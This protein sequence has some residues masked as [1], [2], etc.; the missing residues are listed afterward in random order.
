M[1]LLTELDFSLP[2]K[3]PVVIFSLVLFIILFSPI[4]FNKIKVPHI[5]GLILAGVIIGPY[6]FNLLLRDSSIVL[7]GTV[8]LIYIMFTAGLEI[9]MEEF[10]KTRVKSLVFGLFT[11][12]VPIIL[13]TAAAYYILKFSIPSA[14]LLASM[15]SAHTLLAYPIV[16]KYGITRMK[17]VTLT[18]GGT[19]IT[20]ILSLLVL[21]VVTGM[22][23]GEIGAAFWLRLVVS[24]AIFGVI[25]FLGFPL[26][27]RWF[28]KQFD[29]NISQYIFVLAMVFL[30]SFLAEVAGLE[31][32]VGAFL[33]GLA[34]NRFIPHVSPLMNRIDFVGNAFFIPFFLIGVGMLVD[35]SVLFKG[36]GA[37]KVAAVMITVAVLSKYIAAWLT[38]KS[39]KLSSS[40]R[41]LIFGLSTARVGAS[42]AVV[43]VGYNTILAETATGEPIRLLSEDVLNGTIL[44][45]LITCT[46]SS[47]TVE[48]ASQKIALKEE[49]AVVEDGKSNQKILISLA[50]P[51]TVAELVDFGLLL[52]PKKS[53]IPVYA[54]HVI[55]D[56]TDSDKSLAVG[57]KMIDRALKH[58]S[59]TENTLIPLTRFDMNI[60]NGITYTIKE[61]NIS[62]VLIGLHQNSNQEDFLGPVA[63][64]ILERTSE[65]I[66]IYKSIQPFNTLKRMVVAVPPHAESEPGFVHWLNKLGTIAKE[67]GLPIVFY[68]ANEALEHLKNHFSS[69]SVKVDCKPFHNWDDFL[70]FSRELKQNDLFWIISSRKGHIS[71][72]EQLE[73]LPYYLSNYLTNNSFIILY[74]KQM[75][76]DM[77]G[78]E[79]FI[80]T[81][82]DKIN[83]VNKAG[84][85]LKRL[86]RRI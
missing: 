83:V 50:Y 42:L 12:L 73:K 48:K 77:L 86:F 25:I 31:A 33:S 51:D 14:V 2:L 46:I 36:L 74:P 6:G 65:T 47:F 84:S 22:T 80:E 49:D 3:N 55:S 53:D 7:F 70:I 8:G 11:F 76:T 20:D 43:L 1:I 24:C 41:Q 52:K 59:A 81:I 17:A 44:M 66:F 63:E 35:I 40:D 5:I 19:I 57:K 72:V 67:A 27:A 13:G 75:E 32:I 79:T 26:I 30:G 60:S 10:R 78:G 28:F 82:S 34:L 15:L 85:F 54:L 69:S 21:A 61:Q 23:Q 56:E 64:R 68:A 71:Y 37:I 4:L 9:D 29:D 45:I 58:A 39:F 16:S 18:I 38:Q 62:D